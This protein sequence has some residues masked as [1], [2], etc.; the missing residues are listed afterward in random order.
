MKIITPIF[1][2]FASFLGFIVNDTFPK[3]TNFVKVAFPSNVN[4]ESIQIVS[5]NLG[6]DAKRKDS[7]K[8]YFLEVQ[9]SIHHLTSFI[10]KE[11]VASEIEG[12]KMVICLQEVDFNKNRS[13]NKN[14]LKALKVRLG[15]EWN[16][17]YYDPSDEKKPNH[18][19][20][21]IT[22]LK[23]TEK[24]GKPKEQKWKIFDSASG[25][26]R[27]AIAV[28]LEFEENPIWIVNTHL[29]FINPASQIDRILNRVYTF[30]VNVPVVIC[31][32]LNVADLDYTH[33][34]RSKKHSLYHQTMGKLENNGFF[35]SQV[36]DGVPHT[37]PSWSSAENGMVSDYIMTSY[38]Y[39]NSVIEALAPYKKVRTKT[40]SIIINSKKHYI[41]DH[42]ALIMDYAFD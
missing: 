33:G 42:N 23:G 18:G 40:P 12:K 16:Y 11:I 15:E 35:K 37:F 17:Y 20:G 22:N 19:I 10:K 27:G 2:L 34:D 3:N 36:M 28:K 26:D 24:R 29:G 21:I 25:K 38:P 14:F 32:G 31:G 8:P 9:Q 5:F 39:P 41:S 6:M 13:G 1:I 30:E 7:N 4:K